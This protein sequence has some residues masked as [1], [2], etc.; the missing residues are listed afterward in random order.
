MMKMLDVYRKCL[1]KY[2]TKEKELKAQ[3]SFAKTAS[4]KMK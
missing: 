3:L 1:K 2:S 4:E